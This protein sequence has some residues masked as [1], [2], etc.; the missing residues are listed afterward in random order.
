MRSFI[1][2]III[3]VATLLFVLL[4]SL[5]FDLE[6][7]ESHVSRQLVIYFLQLTEVFIGFRLVVLINKS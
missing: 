6:F 7:V 3:I 5:L 4:T 1:Y 2:S